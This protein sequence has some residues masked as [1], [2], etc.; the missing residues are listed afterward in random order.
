MEEARLINFLQLYIP[1]NPFFALANA[2]IPA[3]VVFSVMIGLALTGVKSK[4]A[5]P[6][7]AGW[8]SKNP[9]APP[10]SSIDTGC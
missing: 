2:I 8:L 3:I 5:L 7:M 4:D 9:G 6:S 1:A 10:I